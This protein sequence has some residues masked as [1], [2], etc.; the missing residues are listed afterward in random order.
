MVSVAI[1][2]DD[3]VDI[4]D[5]HLR[6]ANEANRHNKSRPKTS[7]VIGVVALLVVAVVSFAVSNKIAPVSSGFWGPINESDGVAIKGYDPVGYHLAGKAL[8]GS[9]EITTEWK[10]S[11]WRFVSED[12]RS[13]F[14]SDPDRYSPAYGGF[15]GTAV[16]N[17]FTA[18]VN[19]QVWNVEEG[20][21]FLFNGDDPKADWVGGLGS[22]V[23]ATGDTNWATR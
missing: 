15:C 2:L 5:T 22:G 14:Q 21:L 4:L 16:S 19:P 11:V 3:T 6:R 17:G 13:A 7:I 12:N 1:L 23:I 10:G 20:R 9:E 18:D 8:P